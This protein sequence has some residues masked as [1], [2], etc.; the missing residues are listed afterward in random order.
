MFYEGYIFSLIISTKSL[1]CK[2]NWG[3]V[4]RFWQFYRSLDKRLLL[5]FNLYLGSSISYPI[6]RIYSRCLLSGIL[7]DTVK[8]FN[9]TLSNI[10]RTYIPYIHYALCIVNRKVQTYSYREKNSYIPYHKDTVI[11]IPNIYLRYDLNLWK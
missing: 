3:K 9:F 7:N 1:S 2:S 4:L 6:E 8:F 10:K 5:V 11:I